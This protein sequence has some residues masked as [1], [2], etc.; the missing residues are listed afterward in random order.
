[1]SILQS[2][3]F[4]KLPSSSAQLLDGNKAQLLI[5]RIMGF[6]VIDSDRSKNKLPWVNKELAK[7]SAAASYDL[8]F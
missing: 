4:V 3:Q 7:A 2:T 8:H 1:M 6:A 5:T